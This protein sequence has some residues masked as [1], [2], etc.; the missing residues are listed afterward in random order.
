MNPTALSNL[1]LPNVPNL[2]EWLA[3]GFGVYLFMNGH[4][5]IGA[6]MVGWFGYQ[7]VMNKPLVQ[8][9]VAGLSL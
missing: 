3:T 9:Q 8:F 1:Q 7:A 6:L 4:Q 5:V 2:P